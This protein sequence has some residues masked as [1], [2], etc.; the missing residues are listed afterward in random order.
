RVGAA[1]TEESAQEV[2][3]APRR[4]RWRRIAVPVVIGLASILLLV[5]VLATWVNR[6]ALDNET[7]TDTSA[8]L[9]Q[10]P[11]VQHALDVYMVDELCANA[12]VAK[13]L[14]SS[15]PPQAQAL[16]PTAAAFLRDYAVRAAERLLQSAR[17]QALWGEA[18]HE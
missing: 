8:Q 16:A 11:E 17:V 6:V 7:Y 1:V 2:E 9:L 15:L 12:D 14:E 18:D 10:H 4:A 5:S 3:R 13:Q